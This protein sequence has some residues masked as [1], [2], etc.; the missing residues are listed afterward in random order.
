MVRET[1]AA[2]ITKITDCDC[3]GGWPE[4]LVG[5]AAGLIIATLALLC[6]HTLLALAQIH[7]LEIHTSTLLLLN[8]LCRLARTK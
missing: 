4:A 8:I 3:A 2:I 1:K 6:H 7:R 5:P